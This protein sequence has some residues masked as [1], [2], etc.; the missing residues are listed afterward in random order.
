MSNFLKDNIFKILISIPA[1]C[2]ISGTLIINSSLQEYGITDFYILSSRN[3]IIG[4]TFLSIIIAFFSSSYIFYE[5]VSNGKKDHKYIL[6]TY[7][8]FPLI[9]S[10]FPFLVL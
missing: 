9:F 10:F 1:I 3:L 7:I 5:Y 4:I 8:F 6:I 2:S